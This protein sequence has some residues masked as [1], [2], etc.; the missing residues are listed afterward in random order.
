MAPHIFGEGRSVTRSRQRARSSGRDQS[1]SHRARCSCSFT[2]NHPSLLTMLCLLRLNG[3][4]TV[5][6]GSTFLCAGKISPFW[7]RRVVESVIST[8][9]LLQ[10]QP[11]RLLALNC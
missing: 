8:K 11:F 4:T 10:R 7:Q 1:S 3:L 9:V 2:L 5:D 6:G